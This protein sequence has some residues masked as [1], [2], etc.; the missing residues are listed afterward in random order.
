M[1][2]ASIAIFAV[3]LAAV[4]ASVYFVKRI[5]RPPITPVSTLTREGRVAS[6]HAQLLSELIRRLEQ[7]ELLQSDIDSLADAALADQANEKQPW[8][9]M[10]GDFIADARRL[11]KLS[12]PRW[13]RF[14]EQAL[15]IAV[16][17]TALTIAPPSS[18]DA[19]ELI[20]TITYKP[21]RTGVSHHK[22]LW[23][24]TTVQA[25]DGDLIAPK[26]YKS[27]TEHPLQLAGGDVPQTYRVAL[28]PTK[29]AHA[30]GGPHIVKIAVKALVTEIPDFTLKQERSHGRLKPLVTKHFQFTGNWS[31]Q[32]TTTTKP[33]TMQAKPPTKGNDVLSLP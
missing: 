25:T 29:V 19:K 22:R 21:T 14:A 24:V 28:D 9:E 5:N 27:E 12:D 7:D 4:I 15:A 3:L 26:Q 31:F 8:L 13:T 18:R 6:T 33:T 2:R 32:S 16:P 23:V 17:D 10:W 20:V 1:S 30:N 11:G